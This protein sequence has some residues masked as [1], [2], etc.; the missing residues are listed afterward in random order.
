MSSDGVTNMEVEVDT[1]K[2]EPVTCTEGLM[3][4]V[5]TDIVNSVTI[6]LEPGLDQIIDTETYNN[7]QDTDQAII[8][9]EFSYYSPSGPKY[10]KFSRY[11]TLK[12]MVRLHFDPYISSFDLSKQPILVLDKVDKYWPGHCTSTSTAN[13]TSTDIIKTEVKEEPLDIED[14]PEW[15][16]AAEAE[17]LAANEG[18]LDTPS[19]EA[20]SART[21]S[22]A[23]TKE[24]PKRKRK[25]KS[26]KEDYDSEE[27]ERP[28]D[29][30]SNDNA[31]SLFGDEN[32]DDPDFDEEMS[33]DDDNFSLDMFYSDEEEHDL[34]M[35]L[36]KEEIDTIQEED[37]DVATRAD[38]L[39]ASS[40]ECKIV[41]IGGFK[42][43]TYGDYS[44][45]PKCEKN[46]KSTFIIRHIKLHD[47]PSL[48]M[49]C[50]YQDCA[51]SF[52]RSNN[53]YRHLKVV[54]D[55]PEPY[56]CVY[57]SCGHR[58][59]SSKSLREHVNSS[60]RKGVRREMEAME[61]S[62]MRFKCEFP[63]CEREYGKKQH[64]KEHFRKHTGD[65]RYAC[66]VCGE[67]FFVHGHMKRH[68][69]SHTGIKPHACRWKCGAI[70]ASYGGRMKHER[71]QHSDNPY[72]LDC[73][74]CGRPFRFE[75]EL[76]KHKLTHLSPQERMA[77]RCSFC[78]IIFD[79]ISHRERHEQRHK[80]NDTFQCEDCSKMFKNEKNLRHHYKTHHERPHPKK[81]NR[82]KPAKT[83]HPKDDD[84]PNANSKPASASGSGG[85][86]S[87]SGSV[88][89]EK[90][91]PPK[92]PCHMCDI[93][94]MFALTALRRHLARKHSTNFKCTKEGCEKTF[95]K[96]YQFD[97]HMKLH[98]H[99][100]C[101]MC[102]KEFKRKQNA[103]IHLMGVH[104]LTK[105]DLATLGR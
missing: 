8:K 79:S 68:L 56:M 101:H 89:K 93:P 44:K 23:P 26:Y 88:K 17:I 11:V 61:A 92:Y 80:D 66:D 94:V 30:D 64:L 104:G 63:G 5:P 49:K 34:D 13:T 84:D 86:S 54:H 32:V 27:N 21:K 7:N 19:P 45:C 40:K 65:M 20:A 16:R 39:L 98:M 83:D 85:S 102:G 42:V 67:R 69:Y 36:V 90:K 81:D 77:Y 47:Q 35:S 74:I 82:P 38:S 10:E 46:I 73:D 57:K 29:R 37:G 100:S 60:H 75:R 51:T 41:E 62:N 91:E 53:M 50:P 12:E 52:T 18:Y 76:D 78:G 99:R 9:E 43:E 28:S 4:V 24:R 58:F 87:S 97:A 105:E 55:D 71:A 72:K 33:D 95:A 103:D 1:I 2:E 70:F 15:E 14:D 48:S 31:D 59:E 6:K 22:V 96:Q 3:T 25:P